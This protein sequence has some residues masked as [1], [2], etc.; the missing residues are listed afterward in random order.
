MVY[1][2]WTCPA[3]K[4][5]VVSNSYRHH[6]MDFCKCKK[7]GCDLEHY[8]LRWS[9]EGIIAMKTAIAYNY[10][11]FEEIIICLEKQGFKPFFVI[12]ESL[13]LD[14]SIVMMVQCF[15]DECCETLI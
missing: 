5:I 4:D 13:Y 15:E 11:F 9:G 14:I 7:S 1:I 3:C 10:N 12:G 8:G 2:K 6:Q